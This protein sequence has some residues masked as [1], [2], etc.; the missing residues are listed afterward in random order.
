M[1]MLTGQRSI[2][3]VIMNFVAIKII[4]E[5]DDIYMSIGQLEPTMH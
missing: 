1:L 5:I 4:S 2:L 3:D